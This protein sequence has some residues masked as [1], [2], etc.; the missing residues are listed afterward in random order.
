MIDIAL[1]EKEKSFQYLCI[2][3]AVNHLEFNNNIS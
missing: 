2:A 3:T 1:D